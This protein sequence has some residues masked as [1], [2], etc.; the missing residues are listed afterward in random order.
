[1]SIDF[2]TKNKQSLNFQYK[3]QVDLSL[4][5]TIGGESV[6]ITVDQPQIFDTTKTT[7]TDAATLENITKDANL[8]YVADEAPVA[9]GKLGRPHFNGDTSRYWRNLGSDEGMDLIQPWS[10]PTKPGAPDDDIH[11]PVWDNDD[12]NNPFVNGAFKF[13]IDQTSTDYIDAF[14]FESEAADVR[15][16]IRYVRSHKYFYFGNYKE[17][18]ISDEGMANDAPSVNSNFKTFSTGSGPYTMYAVYS[19]DGAGSPSNSYFSPLWTPLLGYGV[20]ADSINPIA[21]GG[22]VLQT[23]NSAFFHNPVK[24][25]NTYSFILHDGSRPTTTGPTTDSADA[26]LFNRFQY[27]TAPDVSD[28]KVQIYVFTYTGTTDDKFSFFDIDSKGVVNEKKGI[29]SVSGEGGGTSCNVFGA[30]ERMAYRFKV[31]GGA[32]NDYE[33]AYNGSSIFVAEFGYFDKALEGQTAA[34]LCR[35]LREKYKVD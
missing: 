2:T 13:S 31:G 24:S 33:S 27:T 4:S 22:K 11:C 21:Q 5:S 18:Y 1:M 25:A 17:D 29:G 16:E 20:E 9:P 34:T 32:G 14:V 8:R 7:V 30:P 3:D 23:Y 19:V 10:Y 26:H 6:N 28:G 35:L 12:A 15:E